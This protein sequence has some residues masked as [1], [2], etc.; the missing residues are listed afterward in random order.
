MVVS[1]PSFTKLKQA[2]AQA[3]QVHAL[4]AV[5]TTDHKK[6]VEDVRRYTELDAAW[7]A[8]VEQHVAAEKEMQVK[9]RRLDDAVEGGVDAARHAEREAAAVVESLAEMARDT[10]ALIDGAFSDIIGAA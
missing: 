10:R 6:A 8:R 2:L 4:Q 9:R 3:Q 5:A 1:H 7:V